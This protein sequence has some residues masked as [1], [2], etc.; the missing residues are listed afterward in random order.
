MEYVSDG[1]TNFNWCSWYI[2]QRIVTRTEGL[3]NKGTS[4]DHPNYSIVEIKQ[5]TEK[6][7]GNLRRLAI[8]QTPEKYHQLTLV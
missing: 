4:G 3:E 1:D 7:H 6:N 8:T 2:Y 5:Y